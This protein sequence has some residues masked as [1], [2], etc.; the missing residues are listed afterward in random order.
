MK[1][2]RLLP[3]KAQPLELL[4]RL[5]LGLCLG[6]CKPLGLLLLAQLGG[7][8][9]GSR[10]G[11]RALAALLA[12]LRGGPRRALA[13]WGARAALVVGNKVVALIVVAPV[14]VVVAAVIVV[15]PV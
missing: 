11:G 10:G 9:L 14:R 2:R 5:L 3:L 7:L 15:A 1:L 13:R 8:R 6:L 12:R 4:R